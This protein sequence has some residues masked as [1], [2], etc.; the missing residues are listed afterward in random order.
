[1]GEELKEKIG[2]TVELIAGS[3]GIYDVALDSRIIF[4]KFEKGRFPETEEIIRL[5]KGGS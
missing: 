4:S 2:A 1:M 3:N 5:I